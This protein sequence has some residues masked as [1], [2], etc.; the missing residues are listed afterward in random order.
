MKRFF[1]LVLLALLMEGCASNPP[2]SAVD[3]SVWYPVNGS[4]SVS[5]K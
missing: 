5:G 3:D 2:P 4:Q 1:L